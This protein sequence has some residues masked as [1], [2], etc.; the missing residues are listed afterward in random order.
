[1]KAFLL[2][3]LAAI[4]RDQRREHAAERSLA[5]N[6][7]VDYAA[8]QPQLLA[9]LLMDADD[10]QFAV[11]YPKLNERGKQA[12]ALLTG[13]IKKTLAAELPS[14][15][16]R[17]E[18]LARRQANAAVALLRMN[19]AENVWPLLQRSQQPDDPRVRSYLIDR[20]GPLGADVGAILQ[21]LDEDRTSPSAVP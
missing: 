16:E 12:V 8:G 10:K 21:R 9:D 14:S 7:L 4:F 20:L 6:L 17:R 2:K 13:E 1:V 15:D 3:P 5:T 18:K 11:I 19:H